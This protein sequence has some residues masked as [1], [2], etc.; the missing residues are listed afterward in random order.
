M[1]ETPETTPEASSS[2]PPSGTA[3]SPPSDPTWRAPEGAPAW[4]RGRTAEEILG[5]AQNLYSVAERFNQQGSV[6]PPPPSYQPPPSQAPQPILDD[7]F[8]TGRQVRELAEMRARELTAPLQQAIAQTSS[9]V[10]AIAQER[11]KDVF[12][13]YGPEVHAYL[14]NVPREQWTLDTVERVVKIVKADHLDE[15][16][17]EK[18]RELAQSTIPTMRSGTNAG[19]GSSPSTQLLD[20]PDLPDAWKER[21]RKAGLTER[22]FLEF[23]HASGITPEQYFKDFERGKSM[24]VSAVA[25]NRFRPVT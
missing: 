16:A 13:K 24:M 21:A 25:E 3:G 2:T 1:A 6:Q 10:L 17:A 7:D 8:V 22:E 20:R 15:I 9:T 19:M 23:C 5:I 4:A 11:N 14:A 12:Q 18:A